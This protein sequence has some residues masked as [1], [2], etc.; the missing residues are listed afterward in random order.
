[1]KEYLQKSQTLIQALLKQLLTLQSQK[2]IQ[3]LNLS[4]TS[5][6]SASVTLPALGNGTLQLLSNNTFDTKVYYT[7]IR[8]MTPDST[9]SKMINLGGSVWE[10]VGTHPIWSCNKG[11]GDGRILELCAFQPESNHK[12]SL[13]KK[14]KSPEEFVEIHH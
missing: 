4:D 3:S 5:K 1:M 14:L 13:A 11:K 12:S 9:E 6:I 2:L 7:C 8:S 10:F